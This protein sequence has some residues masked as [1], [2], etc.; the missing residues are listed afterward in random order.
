MVCPNCK[1]EVH[2]QARVCPTCGTPI[3][4]AG[5]APTVTVTPPT[6][7]PAPPVQQPA[8]APRP[9]PAPP[10]PDPV[11]HHGVTGPRVFTIIFC[12]VAVI[13]NGLL[14]WSWF[15]PAIHVIPNVGAE[16]VYSM[17][18]ICGPWVP[19]VTYIVCALCAVSAICCIL[20]LFGHFANRRSRFF[21]PKLAAILCAICY[22]LPQLGASTVF[23]INALVAGGSVRHAN[24]YTAI[25]L[26]LF[27]LLIV[28]G[29]MTIWNRRLVH[30]HQIEDLREQLAS[31]GIRP[32]A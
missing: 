21:F 28:M 17:Y 6:Q 15:L 3:P 31:H 13:L 7:Q 10:Q 29:E 4:G 23:G 18:Q 16:K 12:L 30:E 27:I 32:V 26:G 14:A 5:P 1:H 9:A 19:A 11:P 2:P 8:P 20:P 25:C 24:P 22:L